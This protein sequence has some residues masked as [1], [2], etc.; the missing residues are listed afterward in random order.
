MMGTKNQ[1]KLARKKAKMDQIRRWGKRARG[2]F[3]DKKERLLIFRGHMNSNKNLRGMWGKRSGENHNQRQPA[4]SVGTLCRKCRNSLKVSD[5]KRGSLGSAM[6]G[7]RSSGLED[8]Q[9]TGAAEDY[10]NAE[11][12]Q[13]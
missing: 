9:H 5:M 7:K 11:Y 3:R 10:F 12:F 13:D 4:S 2:S 1:Q 8:P 6:W